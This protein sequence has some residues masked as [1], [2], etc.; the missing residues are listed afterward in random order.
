[1]LRSNAPVSLAELSAAG[2]RLRPYEAVTLVRELVLQVARG[3]I[4]GVPSAHVIRLSSAGAVSV[5]G[6]V[7]AGGGT[8]AR[9]AQ[10]LDTLLPAADAGPQ[11]RVP[12]GLKLVVSRALGQLDLPPFESLEAFAL[13]L[14]RF[15]ATDTQAT[16]TNL[17]ITWS[18]CQP[19]TPAPAAPTSVT[20]LQP[21]VEPFA[22]VRTADLPQGALTISDIRRA[23]RKTGLSLTQV[24]ERSR[25]P[26]S[27]LRQL[28]WGY[29]F[30]WPGGHYGRTQLVRYARAA[31]LD[32]QV[33]VSTIM[34]LLR[35]AAG[36]RTALVASPPDQL[37]P[38]A[39]FDPPIEVTVTPV[40][41]AAPTAP[42]RVRLSSALAA[43]AIPALLA[44]GLLPI[45]WMQASRSTRSDPAPAV[46]TVAKPASDTSPAQPAADATPRPAPGQDAQ[47]A[48][49]VSRAA[50]DSAPVSEPATLT[51]T[52]ST[53]AVPASADYRLA[54]EGATYSPSF[55][56]VGTAMFY[57]AD[58]EGKSGLMRADTDSRG[59]VLRITSIVDDGANNFHVRPSPDGSRIA[60]DSDRDGVRGVYLADED[61]KNVRRVSPEGFAAVPSWSPDGTQL[62]FVRGR[63]VRDVWNLWT[64]HLETGELR[65]VTNHRYGQPWGG[66]WFPDNRRIAYSHEDRLVVHDLETGAERAYR[67]P[68]PGRLLRTPAVSPD[69]RRIMFQVFPDGG[70]WLLEL[71]EGSMRRVLDD[72]SAE[73]FTWSPDGR[74]VAYHSRR[75]GNWGVWVMAPR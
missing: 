65:Q 8:V 69:G 67:T 19:R 54:A 14:S 57:H 6:P 20:A 12:G 43:L 62:A 16:I 68:R 73:E 18:E 32:E 71:K 2:V 27:L 66:S 49:P 35:E 53:G 75:S 36:E 51:R 70:G 4:P 17:V 23:R 46:A 45:W 55:A 63:S 44:I 7:A 5:E 10:L 1:M 34:P 39:A 72:P 13:A 56:S 61:G 48:S 60:F 26:V 11:L 41:P 21:Q 28:E 40:E 25:I 15:G 42:R 29:L 58:G 52:T 47:P 50:T 22:P 59:A 38:V 24:A 64:L 33:V 3:E 31:A 30:N 74:Q 37:A 9:A